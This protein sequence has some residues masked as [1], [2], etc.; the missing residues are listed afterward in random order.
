MQFLFATEKSKKCEN[1]DKNAVSSSQPK[2]E[3]TSPA[4]GD[5]I[6]KQGLGELS[7]A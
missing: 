2:I 5:R 4:G 6:F 3:R 7:S 1:S